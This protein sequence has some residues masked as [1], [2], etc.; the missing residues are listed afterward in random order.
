MDVS[1][2]DLV[3]SWSDAWTALLASSGLTEVEFPA[4]LRDF[5]F[6]FIPLDQ[7]E[8]VSSRDSVD[9]SHLAGVLQ[10]VVVDPARP[11]ELSRSELMQRLGWAERLKYRNPHKFPVPQAY[12]ANAAARA[13]LEQAIARHTSGYLGLIGPA[14]SGKS[15]LVESLA[16]PGRLVRYYAFVPDAPDP[17]SG[18]GEAQSFMHD[19]SLALEEAGVYRNGFGSDLLG[20]REVLFDQLARAGEQFAHDGV[21]TTIIVDG[22]DHIPREQNPTRSLLDELPPPTALPDG[23]CILIGSQTISVLPR[24]IRDALNGEQRIVD[25]PPLSDREVEAIASL[26]GVTDWLAPGQL[27][28]LVDRSEGHPLVLTYMIQDLRALETTEDVDARRDEAEQMLMEAS[29]YRGSID[30]RYAHYLGSLLDDTE[31]LSVLGTVCR[32]RIPVDLAWLE[33]WTAPAAVSRFAE[34]THTFFRRS[35]DEWTFVHN[36]F[37]RFLVEQTALVG[38]EFREWRSRELHELLADRC[39]ASTDWPQYQDEELAQRYLAGQHELVLQ[40]SLPE[41]LRQKL[42]DG[43]PYGVVRDQALVAVRAAAEARD[44]RALIRTLMFLNEL[45]QRGYVLSAEEIARTISEVDPRSAVEHTVQ[46]RSLRVET[47]PALA[48]ASSLAAYNA[49]EDAEAIVRAAGGLQKIVGERIHR[50]REWVESV[51][52]WAEVTW[53]RSGVDRVLD[54]LDHLLPVPTAELASNDE[55]ARS[56]DDERDWV[57]ARDEREAREER[58]AVIAARNAVHARCFDL[59]DAVRD[60]VTTSLLAARI[61][62]ESDIDWRARRHVVSA[63][64]AQLDGETAEVLRQIQTMLALETSQGDASL[65]SVSSGPVGQDSGDDDEEVAPP[66][67]RVALALRVAAADVLARAGLA[68]SK[69]FAQLLPP[70]TKVAWPASVASSEGLAPYRTMLGV[71]RM[72]ALTQWMKV[73]EDLPAEGLTAPGWDQDPA[74]RRFTDAITRVAELEAQA[75]AFTVGVAD[76]PDVAALADP[77]IRLLDVP[78]QTT[79]DWTSWYLFTDAAPGLCARLIELSYRCGGYDQLERLIGQFRLAWNSPERAAYWS[80]SRRVGV[81]RAAARFAEAA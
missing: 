65:A 63:T 26:A 56:G 71:F 46:G 17:F 2:L 42:F 9:V 19:L 55:A 54:E 57:A 60:S 75:I 25:V 4:F 44:Y 77:V 34:S 14:G 62:A 7:S 53:H 22:L 67:R 58:D 66:R 11:V 6:A 10:S 5:E 30:L 50:G 40:A 47:A 13:S 28:A 32:L 20:Q 64:S 15:T 45:N 49:L 16:V 12:T 1:G 8:L 70:E 27:S 61:D 35:G 18:R 43:R 76:A 48:V 3:A 29:E 33:T 72:R 24:P 52:D 79:Q 80:V 39:A 38:G 36:S 81:I 74:R 31:V 23:V 68:E 59:A 21:R 69:E 37:R 78:R 73:Y 41:V 51:A